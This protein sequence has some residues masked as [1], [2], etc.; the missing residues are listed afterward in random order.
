MSN[1]FNSAKILIIDDE[2][3]VRIS[4]SNFLEDH[5]YH[6]CVAENGKVGLDVLNTEKPDLVLLDLRMPELDGLDV[7]KKGNQIS[8]ETPMIVISG[9]SQIGDVVRALRY[10]AWDYLEKPI[11]DFS[12]LEHSVKESLEKARLVNENK[13]YQEQLENM[14]R[15]RTHELETA[16]KHLSSI[17]SKL[18]KEVV[19]RR[20]LEQNLIESHEM[21]HNSRVALILGLA[22]LAEYRDSDTGS[23]LERIR[24]YTKIIASGLSRKPAYEDYITSNYIR[25]IYQ[26]SILHD[27]G[28][29]G[30]PDAIL[31]K[32]GKLTKDEFEIIKTHTL[33]GGDAIASVESK[34]KVRSFL[35]LAKNIAYYHHE[36]WDGS[37]YPKGKKGEDIPLSARI[38]AI[39][40]VYDALTSE[41]P[42]KRAFTHEE[43]KTII[44]AESD[45]HFDPD[46]L[47]IFKDQAK[48]F[49]AVRKAF[50]DP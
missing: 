48:E 50:I 15:E 21:Y 8:P 42:Y 32:P 17:N 26:S 9:A 11:L 37:G 25:D 34:S 27:I 16:N 10:G 1:T 46:V 12:I 45:G 29:V 24:E 3:H 5:G 43:A 2:P 40:D 39:V 47:D 28:K 6:V 49:E 14:V 44:L 20:K 22:K 36:K 4:F 19:H 18:E 31:L 30:V 38:V 23:H 33:I 13:R 35:K 41:R 7:L